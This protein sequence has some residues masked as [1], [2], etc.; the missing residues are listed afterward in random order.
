MNE[1]QYL[2]LC[3]GL[4]KI[5][6]LKDKESKIHIKKFN[7]LYKTICVIYGLIRTYQQNDD[8]QCFFHIIDEIRSLC[9]NK[10]FGHLVEEEEEEDY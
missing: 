8:N 9:S 1:G 3:N 4:K 5:F 2:D 7:E 10:L 6:D